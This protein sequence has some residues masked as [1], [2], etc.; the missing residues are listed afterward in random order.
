MPQFKQVDVFTSEKFMGNPLAVFFDADNLSKEEMSRMSAWTNLSEATFITKPTVEGADYQ[1]RIFSLAE[2]LPFAGHPT[3]GTCHALLE[4]G[5]ITPKDGKIYQQCKAGL[6]ELTIE[7]K[8]ILFELPREIRSEVS[9]EARLKVEASLCGPKVLTLAIYDVGPVWL[10]ARI[11]S[12]KE[13]V[14]LK[15]DLQAI[16]KLTKELSILGVQVIGVTSQDDV[17]EVRTFA[18]L[19]GIN[20]DPACG[21]GAG[22]TAAHLRDFCSETRTLTLNQGTAINRGAVLIV[23]AEGTVS[24][25]GNAVTVINGTY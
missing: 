9:E 14:E 17:Y 20:E 15:P 13:V 12:A 3:I 21:S 25:G 2:E 8:S 10:T 16:A 11:P 4:A 24:V 22:A 1:V 18:P 23:N 7:G 6:V 5:L 19:D